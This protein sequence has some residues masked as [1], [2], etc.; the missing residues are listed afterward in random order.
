[1]TRDIYS[2]RTQKVIKVR[3]S[4]GDISVTKPA[5]VM[6]I[7]CDFSNEY[8]ERKERKMGGKKSRTHKHTHAGLH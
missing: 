1:M 6:I 5:L 3:G 8:G 2:L 4:S 7:I